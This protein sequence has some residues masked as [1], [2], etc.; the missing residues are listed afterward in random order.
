[1]LFEAHDRISGGSDMEFRRTKSTRMWCALRQFLGS[2]RNSQHKLNSMTNGLHAHSLWY[3]CSSRCLMMRYDY[4]FNFTLPLS[5]CR[6]RSF[7]SQIRRVHVLKFIV[8]NTRL[9]LGI[10]TRFQSNLSPIGL[11]DHPLLSNVPNVSR[12]WMWFSLSAYISSLRILEAYW[13]WQRRSNVLLLS[14]VW[15]WG[16]ISK[17]WC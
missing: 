11:F 13:S 15:V 12:I 2:S 10:R 9:M 17:R 16:L 14:I 8:H 7:L 1:M 6:R 4:I 5:P 3:V